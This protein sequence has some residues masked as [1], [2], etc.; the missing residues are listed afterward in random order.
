MNPRLRK[1]LL[2]VVA[3]RGDRY[4][5]LSDRPLWLMVAGRVSHHP[6]PAFSGWRAIAR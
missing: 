6:V 4:S 5:G 3:G 2:A 1:T